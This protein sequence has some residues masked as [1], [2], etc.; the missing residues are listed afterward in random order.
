MT[1][2]LLGVIADDLTGACDLAGGVA[3]AGLRTSVTLGVPTE[4]I[5]ADVDCVVVALKSRTVEPAVAVAESVAA[6]R[7]LRGV[8]VLYQK[9]CST[10]DS[11]DRGN[12]GPVADALVELSGLDAIS[13][14]TPATPQVGRTQYLGHLFV[15]GQLL[16]ESSLRNH[17][18][19]PMT[20]PDLVRVLGRQTRHS[21]GLIDHAVV[22][23][24]AR[25]I[26]EAI[27]AERSVH[28]LV[29][30]T[31]D[32]DLDQV[33]A[34]ILRLQRPVVVGGAAGLAVALARQSIA[35]SR[36][37]VSQPVEPAA[38]EAGPRLI[39]SGSGSERT[40]E[41]VAAFR[42]PIVA[43]DPLELA[44]DASTFAGL[45]KQ[46]EEAVRRN[47]ADRSDAVA[48]SPTVLLSATASPED[49]RR[50]QDE[51]GTEKAAALVEDALARL[52][53]LAVDE[54]GVR[55]MIV[56]GGE[57]SGAVAAALGASTLH[58]GALAAPGVPWTVASVRGRPVA[59]LLKSGNFGA[60]DLFTTAWKTAP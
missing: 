51:L 55:R 34:A 15:N 48:T 4:P 7:F 56:A 11:T 5:P 32:A 1:G 37:P 41:Q 28:L 18:L 31:D 21:V 57:T 17:P 40:R 3:N 52:A 24:G 43:V 47:A 46:L 23:R 13:V 35:G 38:I 33:A 26:V 60:P 29:D 19:T 42:G 45:V 8:R 59:L 9:Y 53:V 44:A 2:P 16:S 22:R 10:F 25:A 54:L 14:G 58:I 36:H 12:I 49:V 30:A 39:I 20:D 50:V 27:A 6:A